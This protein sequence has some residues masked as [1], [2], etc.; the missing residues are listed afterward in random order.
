[1]L[2]DICSIALDIEG[3]EQC[4]M[5]RTYRSGHFLGPIS[6]SFR[7]KLLQLNESHNG[8]CTLLNILSKLV[9]FSQRKKDFYW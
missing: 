7:S 3:I 9:R 2:L 4:L 8:E 5:I 1:M 6:Q